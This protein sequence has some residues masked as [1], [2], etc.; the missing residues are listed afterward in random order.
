MIFVID[1]TGQSWA[2][3]P[4]RRR[5]RRDPGGPIEVVDL[6]DNNHSDHSDPGQVSPLPQGDK[7]YNGI[8]KHDGTHTRSPGSLPRSPTEQD[9]NEN[10]AVL[11]AEERDI[12]ESNQG[13]LRDS[14][15]TRPSNDKNAVKS[16]DTDIPICHVKSPS[17]PKS[18]PPAEAG[19]S[20][21]ST[22]QITE[23]SQQYSGKPSQLLFEGKEEPEC[24]KSETSTSITI[25]NEAQTSC[26]GKVENYVLEEQ[27]TES[28]TTNKPLLIE[29]NKQPGSAQ[30]LLDDTLSLSPQS[31]ESPY[32]VPGDIDPVP[33]RFSEDW[34]AHETQHDDTFYPHTSP[35]SGTELGLLEASEIT[36][37]SSCSPPI[38]PNQLASQQ[39]P[40]DSPLPPQLTTSFTTPNA[41]MGGTHSDNKSQPSQT[42]NPT[43]TV[44][45][46]GESPDWPVDETE[47]DLAMDSP[48]TGYMCSSI[49]SDPPMLLRSEEMD[50]EAES[51]SPG[52][53]QDGLGAESLM[54]TAWSDGSDEEDMGGEREGDE[55]HTEP[56]V[57]RDDRRSGN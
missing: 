15:S 30:S 47:A 45:Q 19:A 49:P 10:K 7:K 40:Q 44:I 16:S 9:L 55:D 39:A 38:E 2:L 32:Y 48:P 18:E 41:C 24:L 36:Q 17:V 43:S 5:R 53:F 35:N 28:I 13:S 22:N 26:I 21:S 50:V 34:G 27:E 11:K 8:S 4:P 46:A 51:R 25:P 54:T 20:G 33:F 57:S 23:E 42:S 52:D 29:K 1:I 3:P 31:L 14:S 56:D 6:S 37:S 12:L